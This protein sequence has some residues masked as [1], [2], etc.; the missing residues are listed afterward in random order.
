MLDTWYIVLSLGSIVWLAEAFLIFEHVTQQ[1]LHWGVANGPMKEQL[2]NFLR[3][4][5]LEGWQ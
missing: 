4:H 2:L 1:P 5:K 3:A